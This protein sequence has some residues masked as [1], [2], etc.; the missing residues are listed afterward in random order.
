MAGFAVDASQLMQL[1][2]RLMDVARAQQ[3]AQGVFAHQLVSNIQAAAERSPRWIG[4]IENIDTWDENDRR[5]IG[6][7]GPEFVSQA[8][9]AEY[10]TDEYPPSPLLRL[11]D[12]PMQGA[13]QAADL[14]LAA[15]L[16]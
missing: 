12:A 4:V 9:D 16:S 10:G 15:R 2:D 8:F 7:R 11:L 13:R 14:F 3:E 5:W 1:E 6:V